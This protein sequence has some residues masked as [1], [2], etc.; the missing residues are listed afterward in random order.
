M[1]FIICVFAAFGAIMF[2]KRI[3]KPMLPNRQN[4]ERG[5]VAVRAAYFICMVQDGSHTPD[6]ANQIVAAYNTDMPQEIIREAISFINMAYGGK[7]LPMI[8]HARSLGFKG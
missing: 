6:E 2:W 4:V 3:V 5:L 7:Q 1:E 8:A